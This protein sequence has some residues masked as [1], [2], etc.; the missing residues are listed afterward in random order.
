MLLLIAYFATIGSVV[1]FLAKRLK[2]I[3]IGEFLIILATC[4]KFYSGFSLPV[5]C[6]PFSGLFLDF[7]VSFENPELGECCSTQLF[8][9]DHYDLIAG[10]IL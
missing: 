3:N 1:I 9:I 4:C 7:D 2:I 10:S 6:S 8:E 5:L